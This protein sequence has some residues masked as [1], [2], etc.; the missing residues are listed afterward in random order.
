MPS[1]ENSV[2]WKWH[3]ANMKQSEKGNKG[4]LSG[5]RVVEMASLG[6]VPFCAMLLA[7]M[8][9]DILTVGAPASSDN[10]PPK[11]RE[12]HLLDPVWRGRSRITVDL[13]NKEATGALLPAIRHADILLEGFRPGVMERLGFS[14]DVCL[15]I[16]P[17][18]IYGRMSGW[19]QT[20]P[21]ANTPGHDINYL[22]VTGALHS[23][24]Y[25]DRA[26]VQP[27]N[28][29][30]DLGGGAL[31][32]AMGVLAAL[33]HVKETGNGQVVDAAMVEGVA[34]LMSAIYGWRAAAHWNDQ[35]YSNHI[36]GSAPFCTVYETADQKYIAI[37]AVEEKFY[38]A[39]L[40]KLGL[41][42]TDLP[43][44]EDRKNWPII[45]AQLAAIFR[46]RA[47][48]EWTA[49]LE[50]TDACYSP[51]LDLA[52]APNHR[53]NVAREVF[54]DRNKFPIPGVAP[55]FLGT[56]TKPAPQSKEE[57]SEMLKAWGLSA[58]QV[59]TLL[60]QSQAIDN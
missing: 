30:A 49:L 7:D 35:R 60:T 40:V 28:L 21:L 57:P 25:A 14:P 26:P 10:A 15:A 20:G 3:S 43:T 59:A 32:L 17:R 29:V 42:N 11:W 27:L 1:L 24:G 34:S 44:R 22:A 48:D 6:P 9:A 46:S 12:S 50:G 51:V 45:R 31:Y 52:E 38:Q 16:N 19:G 56:P 39:L 23:I 4:P 36:D 58:A 47:R 2:A 55:R 5:L 41:K 13:K 18:L 37:A 33:V 8:G 53:Q 54:T